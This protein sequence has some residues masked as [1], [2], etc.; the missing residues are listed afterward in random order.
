M[1]KAARLK[2]R[3]IKR[4]I[5]TSVTSDKRRRYLLFFSKTDTNK[6]G[7]MARGKQNKTIELAHIVRSVLLSISRFK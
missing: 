7:K 2:R 4:Q 5:S 6:L 1:S 3:L